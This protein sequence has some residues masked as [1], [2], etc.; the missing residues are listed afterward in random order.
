MDFVII[1]QCP[2][3]GSD[4][5]RPLRGIDLQRCGGCTLT[6][7]NPQP[8]DSF[9]RAHY[10]Q[11]DSYARMEEHRAMVAPNWNERLEIVRRHRPGGRLLDIGT[12]DGEFLRYA[13]DAGFVAIGTEVSTTAV[14]LARERD[15]DVRP[16]QLREARLEHSSFDVITLWHVLEH[17]RAPADILAE[18]RRLLA[19]DGILVIAVPNEAVP[20]A[21]MR[22]GYRQPRPLTEDAANGDELH[23]LHFTPETLKRTVRHAGFEIVEF[24]VDNATVGFTWI[25]A[26]AR[27]AQRTLCRLTGWHFAP[28]MYVVISPRGSVSDGTPSP[29]E[30]SSDSRAASL[31]RAWRSTRNSLE[32]LAPVVRAGHGMWQF[33][34]ATSTWLAQTVTEWGV[35]AL[36]LVFLAALGLFPVE[37]IPDWMPDDVVAFGIP[38]IWIGLLALATLQSMFQVL[39][40]QSRAHFSQGIEAR[41]RVLLA[42]AALVS[43][44][45]PP[46]LSRMNYL[47]SE[48][49]P[50]A[51]MFFYHLSQVTCFLLQVLALAAA[52]LYVDWPNALV[53]LLGIVFFGSLVLWFNRLNHRVSSRLPREQEAFESSK[54]R[55]A[56][57]WLYVR[58]L[59]LQPEEYA[60]QVGTAARIYRYNLLG[61]FFGNLGGTLGPIFGV[62]LVATIVLV[63]TTVH[64]AP[65]AVLLPFFYLLFRFQQMLAT[66]SHLVGGLFTFR[67][68]LQETARFVSEVPHEECAEAM[69]TASR[70][71]AFRRTPEERASPVDRSTAR[72][73]QSSLPPPALVVRDLGFRWPAAEQAVFTHLSFDLPA[74]RQLAVVGANGTG[75]STLLAVLLGALPSTNGK[76]LFDGA[77]NCDWMSEHHERVAFVG[78]DP[79][80]I[81]GSIRENL[82]YGLHRQASEDEL[83]TALRNVGLLSRIDAFADGLD[84]RIKESGEGLSTGERQKLAIG[85]ALLRRPVLLILDEP[86]ASMDLESESRIRDVLHRLSGRCTVI[87]VS[88]RTAVSALADHVLRLD[89]RS[90]QAGTPLAGVTEATS[91]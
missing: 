29:A 62:F 89:A 26:T 79:Y 31:A 88:H 46:D 39:S 42:R 27:L 25:S 20:L 23:L 32:Q 45:A 30:A 66:V 77:A 58:A 8:T 33:V 90:S 36:L 67:I 83:R 19:P 63:H 16:G 24:G 68:H 91:P 5:L 78:S 57:N 85:R 74:G 2:V 40:V 72:V 22:T 80:L 3:C 12:G 38:S 65:Q 18:A 13:C 4:Q 82:T 35:A 14:R 10:D 87:L 56:R 59:R 47:T 71:G 43:H 51:V 15:L 37:S 55:L 61:F 60:R 86:T 6:L 44:G 9:I 75:K 69:R 28:A 34:V 54:I 49:F 52:M 76:A 1:A 48:A 7:R 73:G 84:Y 11:G 21:E 64:S 50:R 81:A 41:L 70:F 53:A 17:L